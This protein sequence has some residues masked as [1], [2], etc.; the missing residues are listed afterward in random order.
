MQIVWKPTVPS[1][2][3]DKTRQRHVEYWDQ[4]V[5]GAAVAQL[6]LLALTGR[7]DLDPRVKESSQN[8]HLPRWWSF[9]GDYA[10]MLTQPSKL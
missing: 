3:A 2:Q 10:A 5:I 1:E 6:K 9:S 7:G 4:G 8:R